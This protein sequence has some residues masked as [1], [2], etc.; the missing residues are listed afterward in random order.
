MAFIEEC[1]VPQAIVTVNPDIFTN[2]VVPEYQLDRRVDLIIT[3]WQQGTVDKSTL[4]GYAIDQLGIAVSLAECLLVDNRADNVLAWRSKG[5]AAYHFRG[6][7][8]F[9]EEFAVVIKG[10]RMIKS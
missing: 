3:S 6:E 4:C 7:N 10:E 8:A 5:G 2:I 1:S 9:C